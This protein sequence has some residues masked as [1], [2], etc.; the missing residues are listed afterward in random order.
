MNPHT[1]QRLSVDEAVSALAPEVRR[2]RR[3]HGP[4]LGRPYLEWRRRLDNLMGYGP[5]RDI[6]HS[7]LLAIYEGATP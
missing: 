6:A 3:Q 5:D 7:R 4:D 2:L 1:A